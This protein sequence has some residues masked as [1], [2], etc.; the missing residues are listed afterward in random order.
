LLDRTAVASFRGIAEEL[1]ILAFGR[2]GHVASREVI[3]SLVKKATDAV[4]LSGFSLQFV[5]SEWFNVV[6]AWQVP[7]I[8]SY[9][10]IPRMGRRTRLGAKQRGAIWPISER[11]RE[12]LRNEG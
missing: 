8:E 1:H 4:G 5:L 9:G 7:N 10:P 3:R 2:K 12:G 11:V 6:D